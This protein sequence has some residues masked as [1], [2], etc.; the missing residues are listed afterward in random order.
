VGRD[1]VE[2]AGLG[3]PERVQPDAAEFGRLED[4]REATLAPV[5]RIER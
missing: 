4:V 1:V 5:V 3:V 2:Q